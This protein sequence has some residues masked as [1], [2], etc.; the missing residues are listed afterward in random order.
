MAIGEHIEE[1]EHNK[2][3]IVQVSLRQNGYS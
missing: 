2:T 3:N 1:Q